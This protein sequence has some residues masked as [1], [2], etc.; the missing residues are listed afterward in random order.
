[1]FPNL[2]KQQAIEK[3]EENPENNLF[4]VVTA[5]DEAFEMEGILLEESSISKK[6]PSPF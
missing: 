1:M 6:K 4:V 2:S 5:K 3:Y